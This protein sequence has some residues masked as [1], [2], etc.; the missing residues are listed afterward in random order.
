MV[1]ERSSMI[2]LEPLNCFTSTSFSSSL[3]KASREAERSWRATL[4]R[5]IVRV[6]VA[7]TLPD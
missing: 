6:S 7:E 5:V 2:L 1:Y 3:P 4:H